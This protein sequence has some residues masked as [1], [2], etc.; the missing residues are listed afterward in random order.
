[1][2]AFNHFEHALRT[3]HKREATTAFAEDFG[4]EMWDFLRAHPE[5]QNLFSQGMKSVD[6][7]GRVVPC[8]VLMHF[9]QT[10]ALI[11]PAELP[12]TRL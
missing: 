3:C 11:Y 4:S 5:R 9:H 10:F 8:N 6:A 7:L 2:A 1:M 12:C